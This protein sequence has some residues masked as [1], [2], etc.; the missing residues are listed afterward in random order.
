[1]TRKATRSEQ[2]AVRLAPAE[3]KYLE[4]ASLDDGIPETSSWIRLVVGAYL[5]AKAAKAREATA[6]A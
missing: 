6:T 5:E 2:I 4:F 3:K 1:M